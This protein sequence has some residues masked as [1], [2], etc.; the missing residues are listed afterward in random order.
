MPNPERVADHIPV[1][2]S[3]PKPMPR[4]GRTRRNLPEDVWRER[5]VHSARVLFA[6]EG[7]DGPSMD[8]I[9]KLAGLSRARLYRI[10]PSR[11]DVFNAVITDEARRL[12]GE[13]LLAL[14]GASTTREKVHAMVAVFF[15]YV[16]NWHERHRVFYTTD[17][18][19]DPAVGASLRV[20][21][22]ALAENLAHHLVTASDRPA[23][24]TDAGVPLV[25]NGV[26]ALAEGA[27]TSWLSGPR[28]D[29]A[30]A[31]ELVTNTALRALDA[32]A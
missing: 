10:F 25:A 6:E 9:A 13:L 27:A 20:V 23:W 19:S 4:P 1:Q 3:L 18:G 11:R 22:T 12:G 29:R 2:R 31:I 14:A 30:R 32:S 7:Y 8:E 26:I 5:I 15:G 17:A 28:I 16:E 21:R 24:L